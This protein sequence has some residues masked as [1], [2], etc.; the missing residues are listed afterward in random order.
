MGSVG[1]GY[2]MTETGARNTSYPGHHKVVHKDPQT[3]P[4]RR[5]ETSVLVRSNEKKKKI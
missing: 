5:V 4:L 2:I 1:N 3:G